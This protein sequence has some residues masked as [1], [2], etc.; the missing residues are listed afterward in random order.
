VPLQHRLKR[1][2]IVLRA[3]SAM[4]MVFWLWKTHAEVAPSLWGA[5]GDIF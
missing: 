5:A 4:L 2:G 3:V 1:Y